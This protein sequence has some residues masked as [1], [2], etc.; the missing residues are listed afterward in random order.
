MAGDYGLTFRHSH[1]VIHCE[2]LPLKKQCQDKY[3]NLRP[4]A[5]ALTQKNKSIQIVLKYFVPTKMDTAL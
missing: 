3:L 1:I 4:H 5:N 2:S